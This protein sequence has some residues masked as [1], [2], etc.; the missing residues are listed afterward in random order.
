VQRPPLQFVLD[1]NFPYQV[2]YGLDWPPYLRLTGLK[3]I[4][5]QLVD[6]PDDWRILL[7]LAARGDVDGYIT[8]D[9]AMLELPE[10]MVAL[11]RTMLTLVVTMGV[12]HNP[13]R[14]TGLLMTY[15]PEIAKRTLYRS[16]RRSTIYRLSAAQLGQFQLRPNQR[17][18]KSLSQ[19]WH[20][21]CA[22]C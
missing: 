22:D 8:N 17:L 16:P 19:D 11:S 21:G 14:A 1:H 18:D 4:A 7:Q 15:L 2:V 6:E 5:P 13:V 9:A 20:E 10:E 12:G 3:D